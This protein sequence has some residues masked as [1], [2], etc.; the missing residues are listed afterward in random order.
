MASRGAAAVGIFAGLLA[1]GGA[2]WAFLSIPILQKEDAYLVEHGVKVQGTVLAHHQDWTRDSHTDYKRYHYSL[3][4]QYFDQVPSKSFGVTKAVYDR[5]RSFQ[6]VEVV[7]DP[8]NPTFAKLT[9][10]LAEN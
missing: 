9:G 8:K 7:Y 2:A 1:L 4:V 10:D 5:V 6:R 3:E